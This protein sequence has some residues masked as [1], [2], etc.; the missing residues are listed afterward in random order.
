MLQLETKISSSD[1]RFGRQLF[2]L[3]E[4]QIVRLA[5]K[6]RDIF[7]VDNIA[8]GFANLRCLRDIINNNTSQTKI[9]KLPLYRNLINPCFLLA[10]CFELKLNHSKGTREIVRGASFLAIL[11]SLASVFFHKKYMPKSIKRIFIPRARGDM[12]PFGVVSFKD[13]IV[14]Q[15]LK[16]ILTLRF[17]RVFSYFSYGFRLR[18]NPHSALKHIYI[19]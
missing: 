1:H 2:K 9:L 3:Y 17:E 12:R 18:R 7:T 8:I 11:I 13:N 6:V 14:Q 16:F 4:K 19:Y 10:V 5:R 15:V